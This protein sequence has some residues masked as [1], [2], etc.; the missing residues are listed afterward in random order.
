MACQVMLYKVS[1]YGISDIGLVRHNNEDFWRQLLD[2]QFFVLADGMGGH[3]A[4]E[5][6]SKECV[7]Y[8][9]ALF[10]Q[11]F[12]S[13]LPTLA[14]TKER[15]CEMIQ[16]VNLM[17]YQMG[18][19]NQGLKGMG[20]TLCCLFLH[21]E[22]LIYGHVGDSRIYRFR[23]HQL[24]QLTQDHSLLRELIEL[25][26]LSEQQAQDFLYKNIIT[27]AIGTE[28]FVEP[29]IQ[30]AP[31]EVGDMLLMCTDGLTD[32]VSQEEIQTI[33][34]QTPEQEIAKQLVKRAKQ[35]GGHDN[36]TVV[37]VKVH[38]KYESHLS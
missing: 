32:L 36:I 11:S 16:Q 26:Q 4:G 12:S 27:K 34:K 33:L 29:T 18:R 23:A 22:G 35:K 13:S 6:A 8:L 31:L 1:V 24:E 3:K 21:P 9:C 17:I 15:L 7:N 10:R 5:V 2:E 28:P 19:E 30:H 38:N 14:Q 25:G 37:V 20:T